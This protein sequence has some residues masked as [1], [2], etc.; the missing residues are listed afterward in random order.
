MEAEV[1]ERPPTPDEASGPEHGPPV[2]LA[3]EEGDVPDRCI[4]RGTD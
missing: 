3:G 1:M 2:L 4:F